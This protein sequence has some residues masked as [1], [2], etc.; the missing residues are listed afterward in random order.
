ME[1]H[2]KELWYRKCA[3]NFTEALPIGNGRLGGMV[4][5]GAKHE[6]I[7]LNE[8]TLW[9]GFPRDKSSDTV[10][11]GFVE[12]KAALARG[13]RTEA[14]HKHWEKFLCEFTEIYEPA[15][16]HTIEFYGF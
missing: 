16:E 1:K 10:Y 12:A 13:D 4:Y 14:E 7:S 5:G 11:E 9:S 6:K 8:D 2:N 3:R 15:R